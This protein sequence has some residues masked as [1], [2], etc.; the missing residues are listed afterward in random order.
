MRFDTTHE[1]YLD[2][3]SLYYCEEHNSLI[4]HTYANYTDNRILLHGINKE[5]I[6][7]LVKQ[8]TKTKDL[9]DA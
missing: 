4:V 8:V 7:K 2:D 6:D 5:S 1:Y 9:V 3:P